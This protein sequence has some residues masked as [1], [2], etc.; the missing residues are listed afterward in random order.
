MFTAF[1]DRNHN[2]KPSKACG[3]KKLDASI[4]AKYYYDIQIKRK[5]FDLA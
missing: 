5:L 3:S 1:M 4:F 2:D